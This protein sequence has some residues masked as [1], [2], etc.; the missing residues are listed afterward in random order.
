MV[1]FSIVVLDPYENVIQ[2]LDVDRCEVKEHIKEFGLRTLTLEYKFE[3]LNRDKELFRIGN[4]IWVQGDIHIK[5]CLYV[6]NTSVEQDI[7]KEN[8]FTLD[9]EEVLVELNNTPLFFQ[10]ELT[11]PNFKNKTLNG[12]A[13]TRVDYNALQYWFGDYYNLGV[14]QDC[15]SD[16]ASW[17]NI[18]GSISIMSLLRKIEEETGNIFVTRYEKDYV[19]NTIHRYLDFLNP[20]NVNKNWTLNL[21]YDF[22]DT[23]SLVPPHDEDGN[24]TDPDNLWEVKRFIDGIPPESIPE[25]VYDPEVPD[26]YV[27]GTLD[28]D[29]KWNKKDETTKDPEA[30]TDYT[31]LVNLDASKCNIRITD[32]DG[33]LLNTDGEIYSDGDTALEWTSQQI[34]FTP[35]TEKAVITLVRTSKNITGVCVNSKSFALVPSEIGGNTK[36]YVDYDDENGYTYAILQ[37]TLDEETTLTAVLPD[38]SYIEIYN[39]QTKRTL[40]KSQINC[41]IGHVHEEVLDFNF[42][43]SNVELEIDESDTY[44]AI[45]PVIEQKQS[46]D[47][48]SLSREDINNLITKW[49][50]L[51]VHKGDIIPMIVERTFV[52]AN[53]WTAA[54]ELLGP[55]TPYANYWQKPYKQQNQL[56]DTDI[57]Q[58]KWEVWKATAY[59]SAPFTKNRND[60]H[61]SIDHIDNIQYTNI[62]GRPDTRNEKGPIISEKLGTTTTSDEDIYAIYNQVALYLDEH[63]T[64]EIDL[65]VDVANLKQGEYNNYDI[66]DKV[67]IK[68][69]DSQELITSKVIETTK[70]PNNPS[71]NSIKL[72]NYVPKNTLRTVKKKTV[73]NANNMS[74]IYPATKEFSMQLENLDHNSQDPYSIKYLANKFITFTL[75]KVENN[76]ST[77]TGKVYTK[78]T[79]S[80]GRAFFIMDYDPGT[81]K[82]KIQFGGDEE[83]EASSFTVKINVGGVKEVVT[84]THTATKKVA[85]EDNNLP[86]DVISREATYYDKYGRSPDKSKILAIGRISAGRDSGS[87]ANFYETE[88]VNKCPHCGKATLYWGIFWAGNEH[89]NWGR[90]PATGRSEGGSAEGHVFCS[91]CDADYSC[92]G[93]EHVSGGRRLSVTKATKI[94]SKAKAYELRN[95]K[96][97]YETKLIREEAENI[98]STGPRR[99][100]ASAPASIKQKALSIVGNKTGLAAAQA[101]A[102]WTDRNLDYHG[103]N[104]FVRSPETVMKRGGGNCCDVTRLFLMM[105]DCAGC[106]EFLKLEY[107]HV[108]YHVYARVT[109]KSSGKSYYVDCASSHAAW[110]YVCQGYCSS[111]R[112]FLHVTT[113]PTL[114]F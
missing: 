12:Q 8:S 50:N 88:F 76:S 104:N 47:A 31:P 85:K 82:I 62:I 91:N 5:D 73:I 65:T 21:E 97:I 37:E 35:E 64:P 53:T 72:S 93:Y 69:P 36:G 17:I 23:S 18:T 66:H 92:Q 38:D 54:V 99:Q 24:P 57:T 114:P 107:I 30:L 40:F 44:T 86:E 9:L 39:R 55:S 101:I 41:E 61:I 70:E 110:N 98:T 59:W 3:N 27:K 75:Y 49:K 103:Y 90:F 2:F 108:Y 111:P 1:E 105:C 22:I 95:G 81:Y 48:N 46:D 87:Y 112:C 16:Y 14:I 78:R 84:A 74:F 43:V 15:I 29:W 113:Y 19:N 42:N 100:V 26:W 25:T 11:Q 89:S 28:P 77:W 63:S 32:K 58:N 51:E 56:N 33:N 13:V 96:R 34:G 71:K 106:T 80:S 83:Y 109:V 6:I 4:K 94:S 67:F 7:Y 20:L 10:T 79:N 45:T 60:M 102:S 52:Q 68:L